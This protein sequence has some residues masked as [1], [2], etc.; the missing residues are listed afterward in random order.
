MSTTMPIEEV[1]IRPIRPRDAPG[2]ERFY[3]GLSDESRR[4]RFFAAT[5]GLSPVQSAAF[6]S[7]DHAHREG[8]V[9]TIRGPRRGRDR[10]VGHVCLEPAGDG[11]AEVAI[12]VSDEFQ[13]AGI[14]R[15][16]MT[17][18]I[19]WAQ[20]AGVATLTA[21]MLTSN[22]GIHRLMAGLGLPSRL[23]QSGVDTSR[24]EITLPALPAIAA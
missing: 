5:R 2:L 21:S 10:I 9:A 23:R 13:R 8:F 14:G 24:V 16:L 17:A 1:R 4:L 18:A 19:A 15:R 3:A 6:C 20:A 12:A 7:A 22:A 11:R